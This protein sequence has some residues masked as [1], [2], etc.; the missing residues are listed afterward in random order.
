MKTIRSFFNLLFFVPVAGLFFAGCYTHME[1]IR[2]SGSGG[3]D[4]DD[5]A[6]NDSTNASNDTTGANYFS[7]D[8][9]RESCY[10][11]SFDY[12]SP[13][14]YMWGSNICY[15]PWYDYYWYPGPYWYGYYPYWGWGYGYWPYYG[16]GFRGYHEGRRGD[17]FAGRTRTIG[18]TR[19]GD[20]FLR[21]R[22]V[23]S[24]PRAIPFASGA[25]SSRTRTPVAPE[26]AV[27]STSRTRSR[28]EV[29]WWERAKSSS[30]DSPNR[31]R[32]A[33]RTQS[34]EGKGSAVNQR[35][36][37][38]NP[39]KSGANARQVNQ[40]RGRMQPARVGSGGS[41]SRQAARQGSPHSSPQGSSGRSGSSG[42]G[43]RSGGGGGRGS[44]SR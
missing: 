14:A 23:A 36:N 20:G 9:Y 8:D 25:A 35:R 10:R 40:H 17:F 3:R 2:D 21:G 27:A 15:D 39:S 13:P 19:G 11:T 38:L 31:S 1:T 4:G 41:Q 32:V 37:T 29:P 16:G 5:Y 7:D 44:R 42:G 28:Q 30:E 34:A 6:Y 26:A 22:N 33:T 18:G 24:S 43:S 12:Y